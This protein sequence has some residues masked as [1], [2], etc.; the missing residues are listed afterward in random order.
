MLPV[1][2]LGYFPFCNKKIEHGVH[3]GSILEPILVLL[4]INGLSYVISILQF[5]IYTDNRAFYT[6]SESNTPV[7]IVKQ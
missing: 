7:N 2:V 6:D 1:C 5:H 4:Y 3:Q